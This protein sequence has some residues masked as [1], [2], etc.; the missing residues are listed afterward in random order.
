VLVGMVEAV[1]RR[2]GA[3]IGGRCG[4]SAS[5]VL[6]RQAQKL[7]P[8]RIDRGRQCAG[9]S[10]ARARRRAGREGVHGGGTRQAWGR[11]RQAVVRRCAVCVLPEMV[12]GNAVA[13]QCARCGR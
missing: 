6:P 13:W 1:L 10:I 9:V 5:H 7:P 3:G 12:T 2:H 11:E 8:V 4:L